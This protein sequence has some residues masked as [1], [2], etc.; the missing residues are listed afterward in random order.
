MGITDNYDIN[1]IGIAAGAGTFYYAKDYIKEPF[2]K[3]YYRKSRTKFL[4]NISP[5]ENMNFMTGANQALDDFG[6]KSKGVRIK[7]I[8]NIADAQ[9]EMQ[10]KAAE[11]KKAF[12]SPYKKTAYI[13][14]EKRAISVFHELGHAVNHTSTG[15][16]NKLHT[17]RRFSKKAAI[18][19][20]ALSLLEKSDDD[21]SFLK[22]NCGKLAFAAMTPLIAEEALA[23]RNGQKIAKNYIRYDTLNKMKIWNAR[24]LSTYVIGATAIGAATWLAVKVKDFISKL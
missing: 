21:P 12:Y 22:D 5:T 9:T 14:G 23:S 15:I 8:R 11:G 2:Y 18:G 6:L 17:A 13:N 16:G 4:N 3:Y 10:E 20:L 19:I 1:A 24:C 7:D